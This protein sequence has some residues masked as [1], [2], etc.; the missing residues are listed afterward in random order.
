MNK[1][2]D[3]KIPIPAELQ[4]SLLSQW[5]KFDKTK[6]CV[7]LVIKQSKNG[8]LL[9]GQPG[10]GKSRIV[11]TCLDEAGLLK[12]FDW[13]K[14]KGRASPMGF[15]QVLVDYKD[16]IL[17]FDDYDAILKKEDGVNMLKAALD[18]EPVREIAYDSPALD[19]KGYP[20][21]FEFRGKIIFI[22]NLRLSQID[23]AVYSRCVKRD[24]VLTPE[25]ILARMYE[26]LPLMSPDVSVGDKIKVI[27]ALNQNRVKL[28]ETDRFNLRVFSGAIE[29]YK[30]GRK[31]WLELA[32][33][34]A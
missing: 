8:L 14:R 6:A 31:D 26:L 25:E 32:L 2:I 11:T 18:D 10:I 20:R 17:I 13:E 21:I 12:G 27:E 4:M 22:S 30:Q 16:K 24:L 28:Y 1:N 34:S 9:A 3:E 7:N 23:P 29:F 33:E 19:T 15:Y 5:E